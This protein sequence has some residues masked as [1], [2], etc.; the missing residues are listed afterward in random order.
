VRQIANR[1]K[2][3]N[4]YLQCGLTVLAT[5]SVSI[6]RI[7]DHFPPI[8]FNHAFSI[9]PPFQRLESGKVSE[10]VALHGEQR[11]HNLCPIVRGGRRQGPQR[12]LRLSLRVHDA[13]LPPAEKLQPHTGM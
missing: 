8:G 10:D 12:Q 1:N 13:T 11:G 5:L 7:A 3:T 6:C 2:I 9:D 4:L